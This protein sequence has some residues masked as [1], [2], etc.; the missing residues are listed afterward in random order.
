[1]ITPD[2]SL[3]QPDCS[4]IFHVASANDGGEPT[5][6]RQALGAVEQAMLMLECPQ[7]NE[8]SPNK[9]SSVSGDSRIG[10]TAER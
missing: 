4:T 1:V 5:P 8:K 6:V 9:A 10:L 2:L 7:A 3:S